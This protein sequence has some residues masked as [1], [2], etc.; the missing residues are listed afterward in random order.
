MDE[1]DRGALVTWLVAQGKRTAPVTQGLPLGANNWGSREAHCVFSEGWGVLWLPQEDV[2][3]AMEFHRLVPSHLCGDKLALFPLP[4]EGGLLIEAGSGAYSSNPGVSTD[5]I[6][7]PQVLSCTLSLHQQTQP[8]SSC[9]AVCQL[10]D[11]HVTTARVS[12]G[13][14]KGGRLNGETL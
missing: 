14:T 5:L 6:L 10:Q 1:T 7:Y 11:R 4:G 3:G 12:E 13:K 2:G 8:P 9:L